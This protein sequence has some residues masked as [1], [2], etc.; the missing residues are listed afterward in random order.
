MAFRILLIDDSE[1]DRLY[2]RI[3][4]ERSGA[5]RE[6]FDYE[7]ARDALSDLKLGRIE[8]D[9]ILLDINMP[10]MDGFEF[11]DAYQSLPDHDPADAGAPPKA[12]AV[13]MLTSSPDQTDR[14]RALGFSCV[15]GYV[16]KPLDLA[17]ARDL[18]RY[19]LLP[20]VPRAG[21]P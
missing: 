10:G 9:L 6:V 12:V 5:D 20:P 8:V 16:I 17:A 7:S 4:L 14:Q 15:K 3:V 11:L 19:L 21:E 1:A 18:Q 2:T 13:V